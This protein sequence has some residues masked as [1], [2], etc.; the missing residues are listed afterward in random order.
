MRGRGAWAVMAMM[1]ALAGCGYVG[2]PLP[3]ALNIP[4]RVVDLRAVQRGDR[5][6]VVCTVSPMTTD[7]LVLKGLPPLELYAGRRGEGEFNT[8]RWAATAEVMTQEPAAEAEVVLEL[9]AEKWAEG[10]VVLG[11]RTVGP[12]GKRSAWSNLVSLWVVKGLE[13]PE[14]LRGSATEEGVYLQWAAGEGPDGRSW[15]VFRKG[16]EEQ[17]FA[18]LGKAGEASWLDRGIEYGRRYSYFVQA[19]APAGDGE[20]ESEPGGVLTVEPRDTFPPAAPAGLTVI[21]G[22][23]SIELAWERSPEADFA[24]YQIWRA[25]GEGEL[26]RLGD[27]VSVLSFSDTGLVSGRR[28]RYALTARDQAGNESAKSEAVEITAP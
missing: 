4:E 24:A 14:G 13:K 22:V 12:T 28:Y 2:D 5:L 26:A 3:P 19:V 25:E 21:A 23:N 7:K 20:A 8:D 1:L 27:P 18:L 11:V 17:E 10:E 15:R 9:P 16:P 6:I